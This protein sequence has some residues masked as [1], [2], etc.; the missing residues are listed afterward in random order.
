MGC[1]E[2]SVDDHPSK[3]SAEPSSKSTSKPAAKTS[4]SEGSKSTPKAASNEISIV[5]A[6]FQ[7]QDVKILL[8]GSG[9]C[10]KTTLWRHLK[11]IYCGGFNNDERNGMTSVVRINL[12]S[13]IKTLLD[14]VKESGQSV[15]DDLESAVD[16]INDL[17]LQDEELTT[18]TAKEI[19]S[20]WHDPVIKN[21]YK[22]NN[23]IGLGDNASFFLDSSTRIAGENYKPTDEDILKSRIRTSGISSLQLN[24]NNSIKTEL[25]DVGG[26]K[27]E[28]A[29]WQRCFQGV[30]YLIFVVSLSDFDQSM[31]EDESTKRTDDSIQL[32]QNTANSPVFAQKPIF[33]VLNKTDVFR[34][35]LK[36]HG[37]EFKETYPDFDGDTS[38][39]NACIEHVKQRF[40]RE[41]SP[42]RN[43]DVAW[44]KSIET[45]A[46]DEKSVR[47][48]FQDIA[49]KIVEAKSE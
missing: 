28:R 34:E 3:K 21:A 39:V 15:A 38:D 24:I 46:M 40:L 12:I 33:L 30:D 32:F 35:K 42:D 48:L 26:Q 19:L 31:F 8:L 7:K 23:S 4:Q 43:K 45:C 27:C 25:V 18:E 9:E 10:G 36:D 41:L 17:Q 16:N 11:M 47:D 1:G 14:A 37:E 22:T 49:K 29:K 44:V 5:P 2:S 20:V 6:D 13:D